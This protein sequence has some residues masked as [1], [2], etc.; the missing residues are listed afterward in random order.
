MNRS[1][2]LVLAFLCA[3]GLPASST[4]KNPPETDFSQFQKKLN[5]DQ[6][7]LHAI[8]RLTFGPKPGDLEAV[9]KLG[10]KKWLDLQLHPERLAENPELAKKLDPLESLRMS[11]QDMVRAYPPQQLIRA[12]ASG[13]QPLPEDPV[14]RAAVER[15]I[16][17]IKVKK[18]QP[19]DQQ[20]E[21]I[22]PLEQLL[23]GD[24]IKTLRNGTPDHK[25][26]VLATIPPDQLADTVV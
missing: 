13:R 22:V 19:D 18:D 16:K 12:I 21:P 25:P 5:K 8:D 9:K 3:A 20:M 14:A 24:Q 1:F 2:P 4:K 26:E 10:L 6:Q 11:Q 7:I 23:T 17:R 15:Q